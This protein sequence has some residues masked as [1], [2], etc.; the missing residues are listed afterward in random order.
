MSTFPLSLPELPTICVVGPQS[1]GKSTVLSRLIG[2]DVLPTGKSLTTRCVIEIRLRNICTSECFSNEKN[3]AKNANAEFNS[4]LRKI[5]G[6]NKLKTNR[7]TSSQ[8]EHAIFDDKFSEILAISEIKRELEKRMAR[9]NDQVD[10]DSLKN[11]KVVDKR[12]KISDKVIKVTLFLHDTLPLTLIDLPGIVHVPKL[13]QCTN[14]ATVTKSI[15]KKYILKSNIVLAIINGCVDIVNSEA[16]SL[17]YELNC[18]EKTIGIITKVDK[19]NFTDVKGMLENGEIPLRYGYFGLASCFDEKI[20]ANKENLR[21]E[22]E[23]NS[24]NSVK[25]FKK[26]SFDEESDLLDQNQMDFKVL[27]EKEKDFFKNFYTNLNNTGINSLKAHLC[28]LFESSCF[29][30]FNS[31]K[32]TIESESETLKKLCDPFFRHRYGEKYTKEIIKNIKNVIK[33]VLYRKYVNCCLREPSNLRNVN[34]LQNIEPM[35]SL[36]L[37]DLDCSIQNDTIFLDEQN[38][39]NNMQMRINHVKEQIFDRIELIFT[40]ISQNLHPVEC[41]SQYLIQQ[42]STEETFCIKCGKKVQFNENSEPQNEKISRLANF[43]P[44]F[45]ATPEAARNF[46]Q[47]PNYES[48]NFNESYVKEQ[49]NIPLSQHSPIYENTQDKFTR[50]LSCKIKSQLAINKSKI[51]DKLNE[52]V[53][54]MCSH[55]N[56]KHRQ[57]GLDLQQLFVDSSNTEGLQ[58]HSWRNQFVQKS[59]KIENCG[60][61]TN[62][63]SRHFFSLV[64]LTNNLMDELSERYYAVLKGEFVNFAVKLIFY[65]FGDIKIEEIGKIDGIDEM[66]QMYEEVKVLLDQC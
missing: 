46:D 2:H 60:L 44:F 27:N 4:L 54:I 25:I 62:E 37:T 3:C 55:V 35:H 47:D 42:E 9:I 57:F 58:S 13:S 20:S 33:K 28:S 32:E 7:I 50:K 51:L 6:V 63:K 34:N 45:R 16:L 23:L 10:F 18:M 29:S 19:S 1:A 39:L 14:T 15:A 52:Y 49:Q 66:L 56:V 17:S 5:E 26:Q 24:Q 21:N 64:S 31:V 43:F 41:K 12:H 11:N 8:N 40:E 22:N 53:E 36:Y 38:F 61:K 48:P 65:H 59:G 30:H